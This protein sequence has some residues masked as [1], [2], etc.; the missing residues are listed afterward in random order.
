[1]NLGISFERQKSFPSCRNSNPL[2]FDFYIAEKDLAIEYNGLQH[3]KPIL[4]WG[5]VTEFQNQQI[6]DEIKRTWCAQN[7]IKLLEIPYN[8]RDLYS[9]LIEGLNKE[10]AYAQQ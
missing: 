3:Y 8:V 10:V 6:R 2:R 4:I 7:G 1:M 9:A 5:G